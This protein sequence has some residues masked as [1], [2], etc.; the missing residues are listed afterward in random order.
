M[1]CIPFNERT[2]L[3]P[4]EEVIERFLVDL[5]RVRYVVVGDDFQFGRDREGNYDMLK[6]AG[7]RFGFGVSPMGTLTF[8]H[9]RV[10]STRIREALAAGNFRSRKSSSAGRIS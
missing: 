5:L 2:R 1:L 9:E 7:D 4:A 3:I 8:D 6:Q 10:S